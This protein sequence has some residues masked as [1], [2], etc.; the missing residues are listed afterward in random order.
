MLFTYLRS[1]E[2][3]RD[4]HFLSFNELLVCQ[5][6]LVDR[7]YEMTERE[8]H[9]ARAGRKAHIVIKLNNLQEKGM[10]EK[11]YEASQAGVKI[12]LIIRGICCIVPGKKGWSENIRITR[13]V[14]RYLEHSRIFYFENNGED[15]I[16]LG[17]ADWMNRNIHRRIEVCFPVKEKNLKAQLK[18][19]LELQLADNTKAVELDNEI[20][21]IS[22]PHYPAGRSVNAQTEIYNYIKSL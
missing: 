21:N 6:N 11:L 14:D 8:M 12:D 1:R 9:H 5:F 22:K 3:P 10:I 20:K 15:E 17:S 2:K 13:L 18:K 7:F 19:I 16:Y 4:Y